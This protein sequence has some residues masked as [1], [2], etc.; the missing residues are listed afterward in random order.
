MIDIKTLNK[1]YGA[2]QVLKDINLSFEPGNVYGIVGGNGA[3]KTTLFRCIA[4]W[5]PYGGD[6]HCDLNPIKAHLG[7]LQTVPY[8]MKWLTGREYLQLVCNARKIDIKDL[9]EQNIFDL[10]LDQYA[11]HYSTGMKKKLAL[12]GILLQRN[13]YF[14]L[15]EP[16]NGV[17]IQSSLVIQEIINRLKKAGRTILLSSHIFA[18][19]KD[20]CDQIHVLQD[21]Q[22]SETVLP[23]EFDRLEQDMRDISISNRLDVIKWG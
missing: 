2:N 19:L 13:Q 11:E 21:G 16:F 9:D 14:I 18:T 8:F 12:L 3:G 10:P 7:F 23:A 17:D 22:I 1:S 20:S 5:E 6:I 4:G 15:D